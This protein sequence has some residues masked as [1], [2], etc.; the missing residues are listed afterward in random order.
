MNISIFSAEGSKVTEKSFNE[1]PVFKDE[2]GLGA[3]K[4][5]VQGYQA[6]N[7]QGNA[8]TKRRGEV[9][10]T[11]KKMYRQKG[12]GR[13]RHGDYG[14]PIFC[15]GGVVFGPQ[16]RDFSQKIN[17]KTKQLAFKRALFERVQSGDISI[18]ESFSVGSPKTRL[19]NELVSKVYPKGKILIIDAAFEDNIVLAARNLERV[20]MI[21]SLSVNSWD[22]IRYEKILISEAGFNQ[23]LSRCCA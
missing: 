17:K 15:G 16:P 12:T 2:L 14:S 8:S 21:D 11:N 4:L 6:N 20:Y 23:I 18:I 7:R 1:V 13:A 22:L 9:K 19:F 5:T 10:A 3:L